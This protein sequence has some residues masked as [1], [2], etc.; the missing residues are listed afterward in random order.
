MAEPYKIAVP[1]SAL[2]ALQAKL[3]TASLPDELDDAGWDTGTPL[4]DMKRL[5][6]HW[7]HH[8]DWRKQEALLNELPHFHTSITVADFGDL[9]IHFVHQR[10][11]TTGAIPLLFCHGWP[12]SFL[13]VKKLLPLLTEPQEMNDVAFHVVAPSLPNFGFSQ[14]VTKRGFG[15]RQYAEVCHKLMLKLGYT[16]YVT[17]GGDWGFHITRTIGLLYPESCKASHLNVTE[18]FPPS[19]FK[20]PLLWLQ[21]KLI[22][23]SAHERAGL[24]RIVEHR[25]SGVGYDILQQTRPQTI[26]YA[27]ADSPVAVLAW[28]YEKLRS[29]TDDYAWTDDEVLTW[30]CI[31]WYSTASPAASVRIYYEATHADISKGG[32]PYD[33]PAQWIPHV[34]YGF[35]SFPKDLTVHPNA[36]AATLG[37]VILHSRQSHGGHFAAVEHPE[38]IASDLQIMFRKGGKAYGC[39]DGCTGY[40]K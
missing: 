14:G 11:S 12:G 28:M 1:D 34:K 33:R 37:T 13:E 19:V 9:D 23:Y 27:L 24:E 31:Y 30:V 26:S 6:V 29:W 18:C 17:Q 21:D 38:A 10:N 2:H 7:Q 3:A 36:W 32:I 15:L 16:Q 5:L 25:A 40:D 8:F 22:P 35:A 4:A 39:V 20:H